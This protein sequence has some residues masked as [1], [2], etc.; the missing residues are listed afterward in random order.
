MKIAFE[1]QLLLSEQKTGIAWCAHNL[2]LE[3]AKYPENE[4]VIQYFAPGVT[5]KQMKKLQEYRDAGCKIETCAWFHNVIYKL[6]WSLFPVPYR[7]FFRYRPDMTQFFNYAVP[8]GACGKRVTFIYDLAWLDC[9][10]TVNP[11]TSMWLRLCMRQ[12][13]RHADRIATSSAFSKKRIHKRLHIPYER[14]D[15]IPD[16][17][18]H[19]QYHT[20]YSE[21]RICSVLKKYRVKRN[22]ILYL[23]T[24]EPRKNIE[25]LIV[26]YEKLC[27]QMK[28]APQL[29][30]AGGRG[31]LCDGIYARIQDAGKRVNIRCT[32]YVDQSDV[33]VLMCGA[34]IFVFPSLY[35]GFGM[36]PLEA[37]ACGTPTVVSCAASLPE[38]VGDAGIKVNPKD[39]DSICR[40]MKKLLTD[41]ALWN[42]LREAGLRRARKYTW[43]RSARLLMNT[44]R[45]LY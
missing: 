40:G 24:I 10:E 23:G 25:N 41:Q 33:P 28:E 5:K 8:P 45:K 38:V 6:I 9:P 20:D 16:A 17:V 13:C 3:L 37:M 11:K 15:V 18:D 12:S 29:V 36:P 22:Y 44:Y 27:G 39:T 26:A 42:R 21:T 30:L 34:R 31:W 43:E 2:V 1:G 4:C 32:G 7:L 35:E 19:K 14:I